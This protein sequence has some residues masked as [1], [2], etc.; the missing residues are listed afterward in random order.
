MEHLKNQIIVEKKS[1]SQT[2]SNIRGSLVHDAGQLA[3]MDV[4]L[5]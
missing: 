3:I 2:E 4:K 1:S 5:T